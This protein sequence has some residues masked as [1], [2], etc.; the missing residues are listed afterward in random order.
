MRV[1]MNIS[2]M[3][4]WIRQSV[5]SAHRSFLQLSVIHYQLFI[6][7]LAALYGCQKDLVYPEPEKPKSP[8][9]VQFDWSN[10]TD[11]SPEEM[12]LMV[13]AGTSNAVQ[14]QFAGKHGGGFT[15]PEGEFE[16][17]GYNSNEMAARGRTWHEFEIYS[18]Q[19]DLNAF[20][21]MFATTRNIPKCRGTEDQ[22]VIYEPDM[23]WT[24][25][26][27]GVQVNDSTYGQTV[28]M[29]MELAVTTYT[30]TIT[31]VEN[32]KYASE[33]AGT[34]SGMSSGWIPAQ[35]RATDDEA[36]I[37]FSVELAADGS[38]SVTV[39]VR[40]FGHC[41]GH[42][43]DNHYEHQMVIYAEMVDGS[44]YY[45]TFDVT[46]AMHDENHVIDGGTGHTEIP[47]VIDKL[48]LPKP[49]MNGSGFQPDVTE[50]NE[51]NITIDL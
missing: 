13:F 4:S 22:Q 30:F 48:P 9:T 11:A 19:T 23:L 44:K 49:L 51:V 50:W 21:R 34:L 12:S 43:A 18:Q 41:F 32:L 27:D 25:A 2:G 31:N 17:I 15:L 1:N 45:Y 40:T 14:I 37:P 20:S 36:I 24:S 29:P 39:S 28:T 3:L 10:T 7:S 33:I 47:I 16:F 26:T 42:D 46:E 6:V 35:H 8:L 5:L 38:A